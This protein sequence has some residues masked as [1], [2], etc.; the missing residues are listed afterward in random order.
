MD[1]FVKFQNRIIKKTLFIAVGLCM[2]CL[3]LNQTAIAKGIALGTLFG[4]LDLK[5]M[6]LQMHRRLIRYVRSQDHLSTLGRFVLLGI[7]L[8]V[9]LK[10]PSINFFATV[11]G[12][13]SVKFV[14]LVFF[15]HG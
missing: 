6:A 4:V 15:R 14:I 8:F 10:F 12:L 7:P 9:A 3:V 5:L 2:V 11:F 1:D 13:L